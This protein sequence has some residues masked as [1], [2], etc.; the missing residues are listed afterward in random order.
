M[1]KLKKIRIYI[2][3]GYIFSKFEQLKTYMYFHTY[4]EQ[5]KVG[6][7]LDEDVITKKYIFTKKERGLRCEKFYDR[8]AEELEKLKKKQLKLF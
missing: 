4:L 6:Y 5:K 7:E 8:D 2:G 3:D 1:K